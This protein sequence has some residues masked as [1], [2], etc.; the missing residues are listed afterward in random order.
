[1]SQSETKLAAI[2]EQLKKGVK[3]QSETVRAFLLWFGAERRGYRVINRIRRKLKT[4][5]LTTKPDFEYAWIDG[6][7]NFER[8]NAESGDDDQEGFAVADPIHR[9]GR[10]EAANKPPVRVNPQSPLKEAVTLML[11]NDFS[12]LP[13]MTGD[14][15]VKGIISWKTIGSRIALKCA[16]NHVSDCME[17]AQVVSVNS[18]LFD[19]IDIIASHDYVLVQDINK[20]ICGIVTASDFNVQFRVLSEP[21][22]LVGEIEIGV[23]RMLHGKFTKKDLELAKAPGDEKRTVESPV[24]L[25][26][27]EYIRLIGE[28]KHWMKIK[29]EIDR[30]TFVNKL[31]KVREIRNDV[32]HF[33]PD[34]LDPEDLEF[35]R[36]FAQFLKRLRDVGAV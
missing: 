29:V 17:P 4:Y 34:G 13:V 10:L 12:Q 27:G 9:I 15:E 32:M 33:D 16:A 3:P 31:N 6:E 11:A 7:I 24:D 18:S 2:D 30:V 28:E 20:I 22:L 35:L 21:F 1:M 8:S 14:R 23:R 25:T 19:V 26:F 5:N 36:E